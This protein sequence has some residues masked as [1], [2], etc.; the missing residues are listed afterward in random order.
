V[1][2]EEGLQITHP[3]VEGLR[4]GILLLIIVFLKG[5]EVSS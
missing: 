5:G 4:R 3:R 2:S 1:N